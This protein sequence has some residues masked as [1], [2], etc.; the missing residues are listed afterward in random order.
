MNTN[1]KNPENHIDGYLAWLKSNMRQAQINDVC[2]ITTP[3]LDFNNDYM[4]FFVQKRDGRYVLSDDGAILS[5]LEVSGLNFRKGK[6]KESMNRVAASVGVRIVGDELQ[7]EA[8][9]STLYSQMHNFIQGMMK[10]SDT[11]VASA[12]STRGLFIE[13]V[14]DFFHEN[15]IRF[16]E[17]IILQGKT[18]L[19][20][21]YD[22]VIPSSKT[23]PERLITAINTPDKEKITSVL[24]SV[25]DIRPIR[26]S[27]F[28]SYLFLNDQ[29]K[30]VREEFLHAI[31][32][33]NSHAIAWSKRSEYANILSN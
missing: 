6:T 20:H 3:F 15:D 10:I 5:A 24:Y 4:Q 19:T 31:K 26:F 14:R 1:S 2:E 16:S 32:E 25:G 8:E 13:E 11:F 7:I 9:Q 17:A 23:S 28:D 18:G 29:K 33:S 22:Y 21:R 27:A 30:P 12:P